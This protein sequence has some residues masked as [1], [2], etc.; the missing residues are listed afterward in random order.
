MPRSFIGKV[1]GLAALIGFVL[2]AILAA[3]GYFFVSAFRADD[4][5]MT[6]YAEELILGQSLEEAVQRRLADGRAFLLEH[7]EQFRQSFDRAGAD[8]KLL[9]G[10]LRARVKSAEGIRLLDIAERADRDHNRALRA[11]MDMRG[12][13]DEIAHAWVA[14]VVPLAATLREAMDAFIVHKRELYASAKATAF[15]I[16]RRAMIVSYSIGIFALL[17]GAFGGVY[18]TRS[19][20]HTFRVEAQARTAAEKERAFCTSLLNHLPIGIVAAEVPSGRILV[21]TD[22][23]RKLLSRVDPGLIEVPTVSEYAA[24]RFVRMDGTP[25]AADELP[26]ARAIRGDVVHGEELRSQ[27]GRCFS[28]TAG[29]IRDSTGAIVAA[30]AGFSD[31]TDRKEEEKERELFIGAL[32]HDLRNPLNAIS[33]AADSLNRR[34]DLP[35]A[36]TRPVARISSSARRMS[37]LIGDLL[38]F[39]RSRHGGLPIKP[40]ACQL[41]EVAAE[42]VSEIKTAHPDREIRIQAEGKCDG[43]WDADRIAQVLQNLIANAVQHGT[44][45]KPIEV[46]TACTGDIVWA[47]VTSQDG[48]IPAEEQERI[49]EPFRMRGSTGGLGLGLYIARAVVEAHG[50]TIEVESKDGQTTFSI[51]L[52]RQAAARPD[53]I[54]QHEPAA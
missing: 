49:F 16:Q 21:V 47:Q 30:V 34:T 48:T 1:S 41:R 43:Q 32:G 25:Y 36:V 8:E 27:S 24:W 11:V 35:E 9:F 20:R 13:T 38:D 51:R 5:A 45:G 10:E 28:V 12:T 46:T 22:S 3:F 33:L 37:R 18:L 19:A 4:E 26:L 52:P 53:T 15:R 17:A 23:A 6:T 7:R 50:G 40:T 2:I 29:P 44:P 42:V 31:V 39:A 54:E 14:H